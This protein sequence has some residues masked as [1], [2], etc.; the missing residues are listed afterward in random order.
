MYNLLQ[1]RTHFIQASSHH[2]SS[3]QEQRLNRQL[4]PGN[5][6]PCYTAFEIQSQ[7][8]HNH[9]CKLIQS[10]TCPRQLFMPSLNGRN[11]RGV[12]PALP[13]AP[14][15]PPPSCPPLPPTPAALLFKP[16]PGMVASVAGAAPCCCWPGCS[17]AVAALPLLPPPLLLASTRTWAARWRCAHLGKLRQ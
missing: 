13:P 5:C 17:P 6:A 1:L 3:C 10:R 16:L 4:H 8:M 7:G 14:L 2:T 11:A 12:A 9:R 15:P